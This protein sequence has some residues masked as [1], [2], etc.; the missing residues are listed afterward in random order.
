MIKMSDEMMSSDTKEERFYWDTEYSL[1]IKIAD[2]DK[3][4]AKLIYG[5]EKYVAEIERMNL[6]IATDKDTEVR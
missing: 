4:I 1:R 6:V 2:K 5:I 3:E